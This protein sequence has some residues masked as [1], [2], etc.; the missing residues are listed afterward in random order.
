MTRVTLS[1]VAVSAALLVLCALLLVVLAQRSRAPQPD[2]GSSAIASLQP[3]QIAALAQPGQ[4]DFAAADRPLFHA[5]RKPV[6]AT[7]DPLVTG[8]VTISSSPDTA[9]RLRGVM[10]AG[11]NSR[12]AFQ[13]VSGGPPV[14]LEHGETLSGWKIV[15]VVPDKVTLAQ[16]DDR[17]TLALYP[18]NLG[19]PSQ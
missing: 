13:P 2:R 19:A 18:H 1:T 5:D 14:W 17:M 11:A 10:I 12:A 4:A 15:R 16:G 7:P 8:P 6:A 3:L 9:Y